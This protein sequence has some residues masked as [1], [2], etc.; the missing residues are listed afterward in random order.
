MTGEKFMLELQLKQPEF[1][2]T[3]CGSFNKR[4]KRTRK[5]T[6]TDNLK[7]LCRNELDKA[8]FGH[9]AAYSD[10]KYL[11]KRTISDKILK[12]RAYEIASNCKNDGCQRALA[13]MV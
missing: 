8:C 4:R 11:A 6:E 5:F 10:S 9:N 12:D 3:A 2:Y 1:T 13:S 7:H